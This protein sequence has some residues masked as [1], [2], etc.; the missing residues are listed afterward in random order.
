[1]EVEGEE[2]KVPLVVASSLYRIAQEALS[3]VYRHADAS[4]IDVCLSFG[5]D[6]MSLEIRDNGC[7]FSVDSAYASGRGLRNI[8]QR[9][10][11]LGGHVE[12]ASTPGRGSSVQVRLPVAE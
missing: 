6:W 3:N 1:M 9:A 4:A 10:S 7:G 2:R 8:C 12:I 5:E 11:E